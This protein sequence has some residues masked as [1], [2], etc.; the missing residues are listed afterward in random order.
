M[1]LCDTKCF[2]DRAA[3][4]RLAGSQWNH[5]LG[6]KGGEGVIHAA[7]KANVNWHCSQEA[8]YTDV[9]AFLL[10][11]QRSLIHTPSV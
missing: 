11:E 8:I 2:L 7:V 9:G 6:F 3:T 5:R 4:D 10:I 1:R